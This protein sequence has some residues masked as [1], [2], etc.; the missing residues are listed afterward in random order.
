MVERLLLDGID[1]VAARSPIAGENN[2]FTPTRADEAEPALVLAQLARAGT[3]VALHLAVRKTVPESG[4][5]H[6]LHHWRV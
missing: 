5:N 6:G 3:D 1:A 4:R 2:R